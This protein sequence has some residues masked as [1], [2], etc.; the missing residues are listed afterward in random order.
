MSDPSQRTQYSALRM[1]RPELFEHGGPGSI[2]ILEAPDA[3]TGDQVFGVMYADRYVTLVKDRV[4]F[5]DGEEGAYVRV[6]PS[7]SQ[8]GVVVLTVVAGRILL[9][10]QFRHAT[11]AWHWEL[12][13]G[14]RDESDAS[15]QEAAARELREETG[16][17][18]TRLQILGRIH[19]NTGITGE[20]VD[21]LYAEA[22][23]VGLPARAEGIREVRQVLPAEL[24][25]MIRSG[26]VTDGFTIAA[27]CQ[28]R[29]QELL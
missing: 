1:R 8:P 22:D 17:E 12:P 6:I 24:E 13:R 18:A 21:L 19:T 5:P 10:H 9:L 23:E 16:A 20:A 7:S 29:L 11:R 15:P 27:F 28:A 2:E 3:S 14:F 4:R 26:E 25:L